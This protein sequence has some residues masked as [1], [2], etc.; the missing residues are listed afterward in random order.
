M[1][2]RIGEI[3]TMQGINGSLY[4]ASSD[5]FRRQFSTAD[6]L[7]IAATAK[8]REFLKVSMAVFNL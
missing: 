3:E 5:C 7:L 1:C 6:L 4:F 8:M 2:H